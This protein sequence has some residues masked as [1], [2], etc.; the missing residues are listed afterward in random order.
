MSNDNQIDMVQLHN[1]VKYD[2][3]SQ[4]SQCE[5]FQANFM[6][7]TMHLGHFSNESNRHK[8]IA[9][10]PIPSV[11][12]NL[13]RNSKSGILTRHRITEEKHIA[14]MSWVEA[15]ALK[16]MSV[17]VIALLFKNLKDI[18]KPLKK[19]EAA[20][21]KLL[22]TLEEIEPHHRHTVDAAFAI[23]RVAN[24]LQQVKDIKDF[25]D[26]F[27]A[28]SI[29]ASISKLHILRVERLRWELKYMSNI[30]A[31]FTNTRFAKFLQFGIRGPKAKTAIDEW[32]KDL[33]KIWVQG[34]NRSLSY[35]TDKDEGREKFLTFL[36]DCMEPLHPEI[37]A[38]TIRNSY[39]KLRETGKLDYLFKKA[40]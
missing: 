17:H 33:A 10:E 31:N 30:L 38:D 5:V 23:D 32:V 1:I 29:A 3:L 15:A 8:L 14:L 13:Y 27:T 40:D 21:S 4:V 9:G 2:L 34:F 11:S 18:K 25:Q 24:Q 37:E 36:A 35:S 22:K 12:L 7:I 20:S 6:A 28:T 16:Y 19:I 26:S 39:E